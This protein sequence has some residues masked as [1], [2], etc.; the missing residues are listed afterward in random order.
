MSPCLAKIPKDDARYAE[1]LSIIQQGKAALAAHPESGV[2]PVDQRHDEKY[3]MR[4]AI[5]MRNREAIA[6]GQRRYDE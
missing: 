6:G 4:K 5:E 3:L 2:C 1:A